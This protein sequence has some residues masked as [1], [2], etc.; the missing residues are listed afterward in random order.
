MTKVFKSYFGRK[1]VIPAE[2]DIFLDFAPI[3]YKLTGQEPLAAGKFQFLAK[4][5]PNTDAYLNDD[6]V[7][8]V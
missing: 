8:I 5:V 4:W 7:E 2:Y 3:S 6:T 1:Y